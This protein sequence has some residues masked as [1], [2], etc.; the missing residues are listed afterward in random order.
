MR[1]RLPHVTYIAHKIALDLLNSNYVT[2]SSGT[3]PIAKVADEI[4]RD[5]LLKERAIDERVNELLEENAEDMNI[6]QVDRKNMFWLIK[7][8]LADESGFNLNYE[9]RYSSISHQILES[10]W[11]KSLVDYSVSENR[12][13]NTIYASIEDYLKNFEKIEDIVMDK[14]DHYKRKLIAGTD[15]YDLIFEKLYEQELRKK[16]MF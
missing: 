7:K 6:M 16:G 9:D 2:L 8:K 3:E 1:I 4:I 15:E 11:K 10:I 14:I 13:K 5:D 12:V